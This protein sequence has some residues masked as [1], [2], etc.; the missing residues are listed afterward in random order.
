MILLTCYPT[1]YKNAGCK[2]QRIVLTQVCPL[3]NI[4]IRLRQPLN[5][6]VFEI[7][8]RP[9]VFSLETNIAMQPE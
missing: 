7:N 3:L 6:Y 5:L 8:R 1:T 2:I 9:G 4:L